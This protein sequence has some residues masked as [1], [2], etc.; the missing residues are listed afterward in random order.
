[1]IESS[2]GGLCVVTGGG[3]T[4]GAGF[5]RFRRAAGRPNGEASA[6]RDSCRF[7]CRAAIGGGIESWAAMA[8]ANG[9]GPSPSKNLAIA[10]YCGCFVSIGQLEQSVPALFTCTFHCDL[11]RSG[12]ASLTSCAVTAVYCSRAACCSAESWP[13]SMPASS[14]MVK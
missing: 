8:S 5:G 9:S 12:T 13:I 10:I 6:K 14:D 7:S 1:M 11:W 3:T 4:R 2:N